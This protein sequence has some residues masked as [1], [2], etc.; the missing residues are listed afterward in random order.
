MSGFEG[1]EGR[2]QLVG[3]EWTRSCQ[4]ELGSGEEREREKE[5]D[6]T[7]PPTCKGALFPQLGGVGG[8]QRGCGVNLSANN[9]HRFKTNKRFLCKCVFRRELGGCGLGGWNR[10]FIKSRDYERLAI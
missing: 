6:P 4:I 1:V 2:G 3:L 7:H 5:G 10:H 9:L 8:W